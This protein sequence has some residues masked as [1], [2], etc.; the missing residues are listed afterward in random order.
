[1]TTSHRIFLFGF[2]FTLV[3]ISGCVEQ[4]RT[5]QPTTTIASTS[6]STTSIKLTTLESTTTVQ[7]TTTQPTTTQPTT[8]QAVEST[9]TTIKPFETAS[10]ATANQT[11]SSNI[12]VPGKAATGMTMR[13]DGDYRVVLDFTGLDG[14]NHSG[15]H[16]DNGPFEPGDE[17]IVAGKLYQ[18]V[19]V[20]TDDK[21]NAKL[22]LKDVINFRK[23][24]FKLK[25]YNLSEIKLKT[26]SFEEAER[27]DEEVNIKP[28]KSLEDTEVYTGNVLSMP[29][30]LDSET[31]YL[32]VDDAGKKTLGVRAD[33]AGP[34]Y[35]EDIQLSPFGIGLTVV[36][37]NGV[38]MNGDSKNMK[39]DDTD[40]V[41]IKIYDPIDKLGT[42]ARK[43]V[44][45]DFYDRNYGRKDEYTM[46]VQI[47]TNSVSSGS[48]IGK[49]RNSLD[50]EEN[51]TFSDFPM[52]AYVYEIE[53]GR[54]NSINSLKIHA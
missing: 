16:L 9:T 2:V 26:Y 18:Y 37:E 41:L 36:A 17:F 5:Q 52:L 27:N 54:Y 42:T 48:A 20:T 24:E 53:H 45:L 1:M 21:N 11:A 35:F 40:D 47:D 4:N 51:T 28:E 10:N 33:V 49:P 32:G 14:K 43:Y 34:N 44:Y 8:T 22:E 38:N 29:A 6:V 30:I 46:S 19:K 3:F 15:V 31:L 39:D 13:K 50:T 25:P 23:E 12:T 7:P